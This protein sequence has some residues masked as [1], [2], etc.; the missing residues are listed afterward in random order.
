MSDFSLLFTTL[1]LSL[2]LQLL[3]KG[4][5]G[6]VLVHFSGMNVLAGLLTL[7]ISRYARMS[8]VKANRWEEASWLLLLSTQLLTVLLMMLLNSPLCPR[9]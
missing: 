2:V 9:L 6:A 4:G 1:P 7:L 5:G 8:R 3:A